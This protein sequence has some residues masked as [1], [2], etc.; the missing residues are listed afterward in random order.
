V[1]VEEVER[2]RL[3]RELILVNPVE[4]VALLKYWKSLGPQTHI[5]RPGIDTLKIVVS[6][7]RRKVCR[8]ECIMQGS[9]VR[10]HGVCRSLLP[11]DSS[12]SRA[13]VSHHMVRRGLKKKLCL[14]LLVHE[15][16]EACA[17]R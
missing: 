7:S 16:N 8:K 14:N 4:V 12:R 11:K 3:G 2:S 6:I 9:K 15:Q 17:P 13:K 5:C 1:I 10:I